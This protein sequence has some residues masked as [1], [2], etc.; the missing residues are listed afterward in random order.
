MKIESIKKYII[1]NI[2]TVNKKFNL[3]DSLKYF[4]GRDFSNLELF[5]GHGKFDPVVPFYLGRTTL[6]GLKNLV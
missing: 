4:S 2:G 1:T 6:E 5:M 3:Q